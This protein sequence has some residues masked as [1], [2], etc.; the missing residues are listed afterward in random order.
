[1]PRKDCVL[2]DIPKIM[3]ARGNLSIIKEYNLSSIFD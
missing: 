1:M 3:D 2:I